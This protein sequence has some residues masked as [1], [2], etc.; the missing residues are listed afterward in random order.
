MKKIINLLIA[1]GPFILAIQ[2]CTKKIDEAYTN[3]NADVRKP[4]EQILPNIVAVMCISNT[5][6]G[7]NYG[8]QLDGQYVGRYVQFWS[9]NTSLNQYDQMGMTTTNSTAAAA[10]IGGSQWA[11]QYYGMGQNLNRVIE[12]ASPLSAYL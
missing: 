11:M 1:A 5:A 4:V 8:T 10:D 7:S 9:T 2:S 12:W 3:P 6:A